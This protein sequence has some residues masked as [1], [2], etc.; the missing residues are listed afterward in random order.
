M[1]PSLSLSRLQALQATCTA[2]AVAV[3]AGC[4]GSSGFAPT[5]SA[6]SAPSGPT[7]ASLSRAQGQVRGS[8]R[9]GGLRPGVVA[10]MARVQ[11]AGVLTEFGALAALKD[12][13]VT[14]Y[15]GSAFILNRRYH[16]VK[17][18]GGFGG[19]DGD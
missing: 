7:N 4:S 15:A 5:G 10:N 19:A 2:A 17:T 6:I 14:D 8:V 16:L 1:K 3:L 12:L 9:S 18:I 13:A 11:P